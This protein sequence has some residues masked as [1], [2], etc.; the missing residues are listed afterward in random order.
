MTGTTAATARP[1]AS[2]GACSPPTW[3]PTT[4]LWPTWPVSPPTH[5]PTCGGIGRLD[6][7]AVPGVLAVLTTG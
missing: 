3:P 7:L 5:T 6:A 4:P 2:G 1:E